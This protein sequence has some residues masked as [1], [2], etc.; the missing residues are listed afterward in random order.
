[1]QVDMQNGDVGIWEF[2]IG[3]RHI[4]QLHVVHMFDFKRSNIY[5]QIF[6]YH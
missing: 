1:M 3:M 6:F 2:L 4:Q 5:F